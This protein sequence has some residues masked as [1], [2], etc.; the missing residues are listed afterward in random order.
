MSFALLGVMAMQYY[1]IKESYHLKTQLFDQSVNDALVKVTGKYEKN[2]AIIYLKAK[3]DEEKKIEEKQ[4]IDLKNKFDSQKAIKK[5]KKTE[6]QNP[7]L[8]F[9]KRMLANQAKSDSL[10]KMRDSIIRANYP[11]ALVFNQA[12]PANDLTEQVSFNFQM[13]IEQVV[14]EYGFRQN[15]LKRIVSEK[16]VYLGNVVSNVGLAVDSVRQYI[17]MDPYKGPVLKLLK[18]PSFISKLSQKD[19][20]EERKQRQ[21]KLNN[22]KLFFDSVETINNKTALLQDIASEFQQVNIPLKKRIQP[23]IIDSL[24]RTELLNNGINLPYSYKIISNRS[25]SM[26]FIKASQTEDAFLPNNTYKTIL[27]PKDMV[28]ESGFLTVSFPAKNSL[29][30]NNMNTLL[31]SS[32]AL[33]FILIGSFA[34]TILSILRQKK[35]SEMKTDFIN[36]MTHEFKTPVATI[37]IASEALKDPEINDDQSRI[38]RLAGIIYDENVRLGN[39]IERVLSIAKTQKEEFKLEKK[40]LEMN[41]LINAVADSME[42][43]LQKKNVDLTLDLA[44]TKATIYADELHISNIIF[45][46]MDNAIKYSYEEPK[47]HIN[48]LNKGKSLII[49]ISDKG[50]GMSKDQQRKIFEQFYRIPTG[51]LHDVKGF[52]LGLSYVNT[53]IKKMKGKIAVKSEKEKG[54]EFEIT[55]PLIN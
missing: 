42:L 9:V 15:V 22:V 3:A 5:T 7:R 30:L 14:D 32:A 47:I 50:I 36:N 46:L 35:I 55:F 28:R 21:K 19:I 33:L 49:K 41:D 4:N 12:A 51:N 29:I 43:Q 13:D 8:A 26:I 39:H 23:Q 20:L 10:F 17:I 6:K 27:F 53:M 52:G 40:P 38:K 11:D 54:S 1:F 48:T 31:G 25:D 2:E 34:Y 18:K 37:M 44:A 45:N 24:L 16:P